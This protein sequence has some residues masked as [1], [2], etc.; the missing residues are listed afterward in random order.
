MAFYFIDLRKIL[1][2]LVKFSEHLSNTS[3]IAWIPLKIPKIIIWINLDL[4]RSNLEGQHLNDS[5]SLIKRTFQTQTNA[6]MAGFIRVFNA[7]LM[8]LLS[9]FNAFLTR[10]MVP[11]KTKP[12]PVLMNKKHVFKTSFS[13]LL[14][15]ATFCTVKL[16]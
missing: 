13:Y 16:I 14:S 12:K 15:L 5:P 4:I 11:F 9:V 1:W 6:I 8:R 10:S 3:E 2:G 7:F